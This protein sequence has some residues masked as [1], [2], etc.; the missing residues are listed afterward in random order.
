MQSL[1]AC[2]HPGQRVYVAGSSN[3][4][5]GLLAR[6][7]TLDLP[8]EL[9]FIQFPLPGLNTTDFTALNDTSSITTF[10]MSA[11]LAKAADPRRVHFL[12]MQ[13]RTVYDYLSARHRC[14]LA[15]SRL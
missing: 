8:A 2:F 5:R 7:A 4:P 13:M 3:E 10:F 9:E 11:T 14:L 6:L 12:P 1:L 15:A